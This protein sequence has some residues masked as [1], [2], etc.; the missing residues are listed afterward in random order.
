MNPELSLHSGSF[1]TATTV[2]WFKGV[3]SVWLAGQI[4]VGASRSE[5]KGG[6]GKFWLKC[7]TIVHC[8]QLWILSNL[9]RLLTS[10][11]LGSNKKRLIGNVTLKRECKQYAVSTRVAVAGLL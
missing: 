11:P 1:Q 3:C 2:D 5:K 9:S 7:T 6:K 4:Q 10:M 8:L